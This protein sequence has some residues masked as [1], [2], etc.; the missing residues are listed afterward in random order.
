VTNENRFCTQ[1][2]MPAEP[3]H[4]LFEQCE[5]TLLLDELD[6]VDFTRAL[7]ELWRR[8]SESKACSGHTRLDSAAPPRQLLALLQQRNQ[9]TEPLREIVQ[10]ESRF[11]IFAF[12]AACCEQDSPSCHSS[13]LDTLCTLAR[14]IRDST[15]LRAMHGQRTLDFLAALCY[16]VCASISMTQGN[17]E[18]SLQFLNAAIFLC[19]MHARLY[20]DRAVL[21]CGPRFGRKNAALR[22]LSACIELN[23]DNHEACY[24]R[25]MIRAVRDGVFSEQAQLD[26]SQA[27]AAVQ[28]CLAALDWTD[29]CDSRPDLRVDDLK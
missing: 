14:T 18:E 1:T 28:R 7:N 15:C 19:D 17:L 12:E 22:D 27:I 16:H 11:V 3:A 26:F 9:S 4:S 24:R 25:G 10:C 5:S 23:K 8:V 6:D 20:F 13:D 2:T 29:C 21:L